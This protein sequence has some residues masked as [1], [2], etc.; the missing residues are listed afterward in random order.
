[1]YMEQL[2]K[3]KVSSSLEYLKLYI[4]VAVTYFYLEREN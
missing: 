3:N 4:I 1:M 2:Q